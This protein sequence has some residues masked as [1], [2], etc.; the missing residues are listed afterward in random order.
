M[1]INLLK[2][3]W[4]NM[5]RRNKIKM[6]IG[7][8]L[9]LAGVILIYWNIPF[10]LQKKEFNNKMNS[11]LEKLVEKE[12]YVTRDDIEKLPLPLQKYC[13]YIGIEGFKKH[14]AARI[15]FEDT[16][17]VFDDK[18]G[19]VLKMDYDLW[20]FYDKWYRS[21][22]CKSSMYGIPF[23]GMDYATDDGKGGM[24]G[25][26]GK[27]IQ[28]FD[29]C[30]KQGYQAGLISWFAESLTLNPVV[31]FSEYVTYEEIDDNSVKVIISDGEVRGEGIIYLNDKGEVT[32]FY[33]DDRQVE[34]IDGEM[35]RIGWRC[36]YE[37]YQK[38]NGIMQAKTVKSIKIYPD[39]EVTY[40]ASDNFFIEYP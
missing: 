4:L 9:V 39:K 10:S 14:R 7:I 1:M 26:I 28:I 23:D 29:V 33:S 20:L 32:T 17:F 19:K 24:K 27:A 37:N 16:D 31:L 34:E 6:I 13:D 8:I 15:F 3:D 21:A 36:E 35:K 11:R 2:G 22:Y 38:Q 12:E 5:K 25:I 40:F 18:S 30:T